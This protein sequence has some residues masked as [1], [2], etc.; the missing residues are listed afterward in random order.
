AAFIGTLNPREGKIVAVHADGA[1]FQSSSGLSFRVPHDPDRRT[2]CT[3]RLL[4]RPERLRLTVPTAAETGAR[5]Q[6][7]QFTFRGTHIRYMVR[8][9]SARLI[10]DDPRFEAQEVTPGDEVEIVLPRGALFL[11]RESR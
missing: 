1:H 2:G 8:A 9:G 6:V 11:P 5:A 3:G 7:E 4:I 10:V